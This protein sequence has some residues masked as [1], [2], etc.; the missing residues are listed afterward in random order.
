MSRGVRFVAFSVFSIAVYVVLFLF[1]E[2]L[3]PAV[4]QRD[5]FPVLPFV[6]LVAFGAYALSSIGLALITFRDCPEAHQE[7]LEEIKTARKDLS[8]KMNLDAGKPVSS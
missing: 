4:I 2:P 1:G 3:L 8:M 5:L 7:L 6:I